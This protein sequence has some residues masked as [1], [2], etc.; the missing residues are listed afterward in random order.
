MTWARNKLIANA[1]LLQASIDCEIPM[2]TYE[3]EEMHNLLAVMV[4]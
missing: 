2:W 1:V 3:A 4:L